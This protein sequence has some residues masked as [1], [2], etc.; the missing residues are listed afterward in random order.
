MNLSCFFK[1]KKSGNSSE[2]V[3]KYTHSLPNPKR[4]ARKDARYK[5]RLL[6]TLKK[7]GWYEGR[8]VELPDLG[9]Y[10]YEYP[11]NAISFLKEFHGLK[12][13]SYCTSIDIAPDGYDID[14]DFENLEYSGSC[15]YAMG[16]FLNKQ[17]VC[18][19]IEGRFY[20]RICIDEHFNVYSV[21]EYGMMLYGRRSIYEGLYNVL[22]GQQLGMYFLIIDA[23][24]KYE[25]DNG[26][27]L[28]RKHSRTDWFESIEL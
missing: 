4:I 10:P 3:Y 14:E 19:G 15:E 22:S 9:L 5:S 20:K 25:D 26:H 24:T 11:D 27:P 18:I 17:I 16:K 8:Q 21:S 23:V 7:A 28:W 12:L 6:K 2:T 1:S 13:V